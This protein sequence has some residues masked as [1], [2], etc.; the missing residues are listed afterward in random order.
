[1]K[2][3]GEMNINTLQQLATRIA[4]WQKTR[5]YSDSEL[6]RRYAGLGSTKTFK[7]IL[8]GDTSELDV[9]KWEADYREMW[10][11]MEM[12]GSEELATF[13]VLDDL[14]HMSRVRAAAAS[15]VQETGNNRLVIVEGEPGTGKTA[16][17]LAIRG[18][19]ASKMVSLE[20]D[21]TWPGRIMPML[22]QMFHA[23]RV[24]DE[25]KLAEMPQSPA[26]ALARI[27]DQMQALALCVV[28]DEAHHMGPECLN[29][30]KTLI[31]KTP[32][33]FI[34]F[35]KPD[36]FRKLES[37]AYSECCQLT[38][39]RLKERIRL[40]WYDRAQAS[41]VIRKAIL[42][43]V[44]RVLQNRLSWDNGS[45]KSAAAKLANEAPSF[46]HWNFVDLVTRK[47]RELVG[48]DGTVDVES[49]AK[50]L[51]MALATR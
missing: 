17:S 31:N 21:Q 34:L 32:G 39:N 13:P 8:N 49:F 9:E 33:S 43:D 29:L 18:R 38:Q 7:R 3:E 27:I 48:K 23:V 46:G 12:A 28:I 16:S 30:I 25:R 14:E 42:R 24:R 26:V 22:T 15:V 41:K 5:G 2:E 19:F 6:I 40:D 20:A 51:Q 11:L 44:E 45:V 4:D 47:C 36:L 10:T 50:A 1:M 37:R 35:A